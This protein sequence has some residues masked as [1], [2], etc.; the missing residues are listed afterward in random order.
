MA[1]H[2]DGKKTKRQDTRP[3]RARYNAKHGM[4]AEKQRKHNRPGLGRIANLSPSAHLFD[5]MNRVPEK[6]QRKRKQLKPR[7]STQMKLAA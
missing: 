7:Q 6:A 4:T 1:K 3:A 2:R 5:P